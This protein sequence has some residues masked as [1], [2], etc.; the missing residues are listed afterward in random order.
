MEQIFKTGRKKLPLEGQLS[1]RELTCVS[2]NPHVGTRSM[3]HRSSMGIERC[4]YVTQPT[5]CLDD[6]VVC[7]VVYGN[8]LE[9]AQVNDEATVLSS[10]PV[11]NVAVL[12]TAKQSMC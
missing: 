10:K 8:L 9:V 5:S 12:P 6:G 2:S 3:W 11:S 4:Y 7:F 1:D